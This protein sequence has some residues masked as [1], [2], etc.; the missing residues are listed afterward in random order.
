MKKKHAKHSIYCGILS[1]ILLSSSFPMLTTQVQ[2]EETATVNTFGDLVWEDTNQNGMQDA[3]EQGIEGITIELYRAD[4]SKVGEQKTDK[5]GWYQFNALQEGDYFAHI[6]IPG[7]QYKMVSTKRFGWDGWTDYFHIKGDG[8]NKLDA[9]VGLLSQKGRIGDTIWEDTNKNGKQDDGEPGISLVT[10]DLYNFDGKKIKTVTTDEKGHYQFTDIT[11]GYYYVKLNIPAEY[12]FLGAPNFGA[13][14]FSNY[15]LVEGNTNEKMNA[16]LIKKQTEVAVESI[17]VEPSK[18]DAAEGENGT[19][20]ASVQPE[21]AT[22]KALTYTSKDPN[23]VTVDKD[24]NWKAIKVG[25]TTMT[26][27]SANEKT[28]EIPVTVKGQEVLPTS[29]S[30]T[31]NEDTYNGIGDSLHVQATVLPTNATNKKVT[32]TSSNTSVATIDSAGNIYVRGKGRTLITVRTS[33]NLSKSFYVYGAEFNGMRQVSVKHSGKQLAI[34]NGVNTTTPGTPSNHLVQKSSSSS[35]NQKWEFQSKDGIYYKVRNKG[36][37]QYITATGTTIETGTQIL[38]K[39]ESNSNDQLWQLIP[40]QGSYEIKSV[41]RGTI[42]D[43]AYARQD[44]GAIVHLYPGWEPRWD[45][46]LFYINRA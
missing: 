6:V 27:T 34:N 23:V 37:G 45:N 28:A 43:V 32:Y 4:G 19:I 29:L 33:N 13:D 9:D 15:I 14:Q 22:N 18:I 36:T 12:D 16:G 20:K 5:N 42:M 25:A 7:N 39:P 11:N 44:N 46:E 40:H 8:A 1:A 2:A 3:G 26:V 35:N 30:I 24:G 21:N 17:K 31:P 41:S 38:V 10:L